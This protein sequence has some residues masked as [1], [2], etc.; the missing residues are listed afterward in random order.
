M[1]KIAVV[2]D[3]HY[4]SETLGVSGPAF[5]IRYNGDQRCLRESGAITQAAFD[6]ISSSDCDSVI[7][8]GD[9]SNDGEKVSHDEFIE[10]LKVLDEKK[11]TNVIFATH[12]WCCDGNARKFVGEFDITG[13]PTYNPAELRQLYKPYGENSWIRRRPSQMDTRHRQRS[14]IRRKDCYTCGAPPRFA[15]CDHISDKR[16]VNR[17]PR[18]KSRNACRGRR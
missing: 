16:N 7:I 8:A 18:G 17:R 15:D 4:Y 11:P 14:K 13:I 9:M 10:K 12:D 2:S 5:D 1:Y 6:K 3:I